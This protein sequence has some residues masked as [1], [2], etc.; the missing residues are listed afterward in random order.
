PIVRDTIPDATEDAILRALSKTPADRFPTAVLFAEA[1]NAPS[2]VTGPRRRTTRPA[3]MPTR[4]LGLP[5]GGVL[6]VLGVA[7]VAAAWATRSL[8]SGKARP[9]EGVGGLDP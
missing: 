4:W 7:V 1:L 6:V 8:W 2:V 9:G 5:R 3:A